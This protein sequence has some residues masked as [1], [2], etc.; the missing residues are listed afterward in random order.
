MSVDQLIKGSI[1]KGFRK[2]FY[3]ET[4]VGKL[5]HTQ[6]KRGKCIR[7]RMGSTIFIEPIK[8][9]R[10]GSTIGIEPDKRGKCISR[11]VQFIAPKNYNNCSAKAGVWLAVARSVADAC[12]KICC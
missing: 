3:D 6:F 12:C 1:N 8:K 2:Y 11:R 10:T 9:R 7:S 5:A 4:V